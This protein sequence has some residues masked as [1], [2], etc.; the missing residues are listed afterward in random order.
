MECSAHLSS[1][2]IDPTSQFG[3]GLLRRLRWKA[4]GIRLR[5]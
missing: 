4:S 5:I 3:C 2:A 1:F